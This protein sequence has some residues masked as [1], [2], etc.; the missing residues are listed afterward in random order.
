MRRI[1][2]GDATA[3]S[4]VARRK[5]LLYAGLRP[6]TKLQEQRSASIS[7]DGTS[8]RERLP[9][10]GASSATSRGASLPGT[11]GRSASARSLQGQDGT[12]SLL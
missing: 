6:W 3:D 4:H 1:A 5:S 11:L 8:S 12:S 9:R 7:C 2:Q 10:G